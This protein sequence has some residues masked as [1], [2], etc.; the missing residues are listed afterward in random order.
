MKQRHAHTKQRQ[1]N[2]KYV[3]RET[4]HSLTSRFDSVVH[5][6]EHETAF[7]ERSVRSS[8]RSD[9][10]WELKFGGF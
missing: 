10:E 8:L 2:K 4:Q 5:C 1:V 7:G 3:E 9:L 6:R